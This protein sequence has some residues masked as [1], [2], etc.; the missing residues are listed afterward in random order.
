MYT[1][2]LSPIPQSR[3]FCFVFPFPTFKGHFISESFTIDPA[4]LSYIYAKQPILFYFYSVRDPHTY[5]L[6]I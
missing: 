6:I 1:G 5:S 4:F 3:P 2:T